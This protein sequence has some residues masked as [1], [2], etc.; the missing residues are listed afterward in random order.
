MKCYRLF[1]LLSGSLLFTNTLFAQREQ[2]SFRTEFYA[3]TSVDTRNLS[4]YDGGTV[5][6]YTTALAWAN[7]SV[8]NKKG[9]SVLTSTIS[10]RYTSLQ[11][12]FDPTSGARPDI[13]TPADRLVSRFQDGLALHQFQ[14]DL[15]LMSVINS[16]WI[17]YSLARPAM[18]SDLEGSL[19]FRDFRLEGAVFGEYRMSSKLRIG[20]GLSRSSAFGRVLWIPLMRVL[21]RPAPKILI[22]GVLPSRLDAWYLPSKKW[23]FGFGLA[24]TGGQFRF[25]DNSGFGGNQF[26]FANGMAMLQAK[27][28]IQGKWYLQADAGLSLVPRQELTRYDYRV[29]PGRD[30]FVDLSPNPIPVGRIGIFKVF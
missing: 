14:A 13:L 7:R 20:P 27:H 3:P 12:D 11:Y 10:Y 2:L 6:G 4:L 30:I 5:S 8:L 28:L 16:K 19:G 1:L 17:L 29:W 18:M 26:G 9:T 25:N 15:L 22:D 23:E 21:Y 24:L